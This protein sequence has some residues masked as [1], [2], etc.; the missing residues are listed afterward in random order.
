LITSTLLH[1]KI[2]KD[3]EKECPSAALF[4]VD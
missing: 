4:F 3:F 1:E 2:D